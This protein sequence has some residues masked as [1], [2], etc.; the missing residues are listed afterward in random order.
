MAN[1]A[2]WDKSFVWLETDNWVMTIEGSIQKSVVL[3]ALTIMWAILAWVYTPLQNIILPYYLWLIWATFIMALVIIFKKKT[4]AF[5]APIYA[6]LE[7]LLLWTISMLY[8]AALPGIVMQ[9]V[10]LTFAIFL[11]MLG[12]YASK[13]IVVTEKFRM[14]VVAATWAIALMYI[15]SLLW[16]MT[17]WYEMKF[18]HESTFLGIWISVF[19]VWIAAFNLALDFDVIEKWVA[20]RAPKYMEWYAGFGLLVTLIWLYLEVLRLLSKIRSK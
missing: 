20:V 6:V 2:F 5:L 14:W 19:I 1:P 4:A 8:E 7:W 3:I 16:S 11:T 15:A 9:S 10:W 18:L 17:G 13:I 12:L